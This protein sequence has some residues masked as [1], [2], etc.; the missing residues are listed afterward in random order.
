MGQN[1]QGGTV[2]SIQVNLTRSTQDQ[3]YLETECSYRIVFLFTCNLR[4][5]SGGIILSHNV[6]DLCIP[7]LCPCLATI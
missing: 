5:C 2:S 6:V 1:K 7:C 3:M 4:N